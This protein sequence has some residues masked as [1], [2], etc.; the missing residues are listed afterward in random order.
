MRSLSTKP[1]QL[2]CVLISQ[3]QA[4]CG[5]GGV[6]HFAWL[7]ANHPLRSSESRCMDCRIGSRLSLRPKWVD[8]NDTC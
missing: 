5:T 2:L 4:M 1:V 3:N 6:R 7:T 8:A